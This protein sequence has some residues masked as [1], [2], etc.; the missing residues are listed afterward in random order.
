MKLSDAR[1]EAAQAAKE[2]GIQIVIVDEGPHADEFAERD[3]D[4]KSYCYC[5]ES[6]VAILYPRGKIM[7]DLSPEAEALGFTSN[8]QAAEHDK[9]LDANGSPEFKAWKK[10]VAAK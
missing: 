10:G 2:S 1:T 6:G 9:W 7:P 8:A 3:T 4:G 5:P